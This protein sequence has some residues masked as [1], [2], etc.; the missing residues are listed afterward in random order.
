MVVSPFERGAA[1]Q[2][3]DTRGHYT[4]ILNLLYHLEL[5]VISNTYADS[6][7]SDNPFRETYLD[8]DPTH[9]SRYI[10]FNS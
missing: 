4:G 3:A 7:V 8:R 2:I 1:N 9:E 10:F 6:K 5:G